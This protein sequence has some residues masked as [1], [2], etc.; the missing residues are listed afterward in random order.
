MRLFKSR[1]SGEYSDVS[2]VVANENDPHVKIVSCSAQQEF[3]NNDTQP[4]ADKPPDEHSS[5]GYFDEQ[6]KHVNNI[7][8]GVQPSDICS[9]DKFT[10][11]PDCD[12]IDEPHNDTPAACV[13]TDEASATINQETTFPSDSTADFI[14]E[15]FGST[16]LCC[17]FASLHFVPSPPIPFRKSV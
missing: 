6:K 8:Y 9:T 11:I 15:L 1:K 17:Y 14:N 3:H 13:H 5:N 4:S 7:P 12:Q 10:P 16:Q 2:S